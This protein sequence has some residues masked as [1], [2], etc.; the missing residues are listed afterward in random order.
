MKR[1]K[2]WL[3]AIMAIAML[4]TLQVWAPEAQAAAS[5]TTVF[6]NG[7][8]L[9]YTQ[10]PV[11][12]DGA[13]LVSAKETIEGLGLGFT[14]DASNKRI[15]ASNGE[16]TVTLL[17]GQYTATI[18]GMTVF[19][20]SPPTQINGR[21]MV[22]LKV[23]LD[24]VGANV[25]TK[26]T[27]I[28]IKTGSA[29]KTRYY[30]GL[31]LQVTNSTVK[32]LGGNAIN[33]E[34]VQFS[35]YDGDIYTT[36]YTIAL[37][38]GQK[39]AFEQPAATLGD[40]IYIEGQE[41]AFL[42]RAIHS[43]SKQGQ[44]TPSLSYQISE[45]TYLGDA[46]MD[47]ILALIDKATEQ[48]KQALKKELAANKNIPL[49]VGGSYITYNSLGYP[50]AN[51]ELKNLTGKTIT[52]FEL[53]FSCYDAYGDPVH[54]AGNN[55]FYGKANGESIAS[56]GT[57]T[58]KWDLTWYEDTTKLVNISIDKVAYSDGTSWKRK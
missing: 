57:Y 46:F 18:N 51:I 40:S 36:N 25:T 5:D 30:T 37:A 43:M 14:W 1:R 41:Y 15:I 42:G 27:Q 22:P 34:Y 53:S 48:M 4:L 33:V 12:R 20:N 16:T 28:S 7:V 50:E 56:G 55:R 2:Q 23:L 39:A 54:F 35:Y 6:V 24:A 26:G 13:T 49:K 11:V 38:P 9:K 32:N 10:P 21:T 17:L 19:L 58:F 47:N 45:Q 52:A 8:R 3:A 29:K 31:P 44:V